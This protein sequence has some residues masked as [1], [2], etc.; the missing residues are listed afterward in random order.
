M[1]DYQCFPLWEIGENIYDNI[2]PNDLPISQEL[3]RDL[4]AWADTYESFLNLEDPLNSRFVSEEEEKQFE[5]DG[6]NLQKRL[7]EELGENFKIDL[8]SPKD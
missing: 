6:E 7:Q 8:F 5:T 3:K 1:P 2:D 4:Y